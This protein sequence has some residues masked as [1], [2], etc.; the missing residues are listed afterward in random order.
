MPG[1]AATDPSVYAILARSAYGAPLDIQAWLP[2]LSDTVE[3]ELRM[4]FAVGEYGVLGVEPNERADHLMQVWQATQEA[5][6]IGNGIYTYGPFQPDP[7]D[8]TDPAIAAQLQLMD[9]NGTPVD[10]AWARLSGA[11]HSQQETER[12]DRLRPSILLATP[13]FREALAAWGGYASSGPVKD[14]L[15]IKQYY[16][17][18]KREDRALAF[19]LTWEPEKIK[20]QFSE[21]DRVV[22]D[23]LGEFTL[24]GAF[25]KEYLT[26]GGY[27]HFGAPVSNAHPQVAAGEELFVQ[28]FA[29]GWTI[30]QRKSTAAR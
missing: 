11:W 28:E 4:P 9:E 2:K 25:L 27:A 30:F 1:Q 23:E 29:K 24:E 26:Q 16:L 20:V 8:L 14:G 18:G 13:A 22:F 10:N 19:S 3:N 6:A 12:A 15:S 21:V 7:N 5:S 17:E